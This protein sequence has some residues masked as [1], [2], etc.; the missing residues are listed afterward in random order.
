MLFICR[1]K[2]STFR[3]LF[4]NIAKTGVLQVRNL[5]LGAFHRILPC[6][7][8][9]CYTAKPPAFLLADRF[10]RDQK[11]LFAQRPCLSAVIAVREK[12]KSHLP[13][14]ENIRHFIYDSAE[15][16]FLGRQE[17]AASPHSAHFVKKTKIELSAHLKIDT[18]DILYDHSLALFIFYES[19]TDTEK[20][21]RLSIK[22]CCLI[23][24][25]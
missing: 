14:R 10:L 16:I 6:F 21:S 9:R 20:S 4:H 15:L 11:T 25:V 22:I 17:S 24:D 8:K 3:I 5:S 23:C 1:R 18:V 2:R 19:R 12:G 7:M 13:Q